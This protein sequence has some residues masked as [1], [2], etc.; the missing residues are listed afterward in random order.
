MPRV[1]KR[2]SVAANQRASVDAIKRSAE[3]IGAALM[4]R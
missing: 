3:V 1:S 4:R 2:Q